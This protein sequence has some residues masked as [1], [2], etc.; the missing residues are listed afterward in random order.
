MLEWK[1]KAKMREETIGQL[2]SE[3]EGLRRERSFIL[4]KDNKTKAENELK[5][6]MQSENLVKI[7]LERD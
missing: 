3:I 6:K 4:D 7:T 2:K 1:R 5:M